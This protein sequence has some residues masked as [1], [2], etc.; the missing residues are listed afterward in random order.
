VFPTTDSS[1]SEENKLYLWVLRCHAVPEWATDNSDCSDS[2]S[3]HN[4]ANG[5]F[6]KTPLVSRVL[7]RMDQREYLCTEQS[8]EDSH[9][10]NVYL[11]NALIINEVTASKQKRLHDLSK[12]LITTINWYGCRSPDGRL[13]HIRGL[14]A[15]KLLSPSFS[16]VRITTKTPK[17]LEL[18]RS[19]RLSSS[20]SSWQSSE[21][22]AGAQA[23]GHMKTTSWQTGCGVVCGVWVPAVRTPGT[24]YSLIVH[25]AP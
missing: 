12:C 1:F 3:C 9:V 20:N 13:F 22:Q 17:W 14:V 16:W 11:Y 7:I 2:T 10:H 18:H 25:G 21:R 23:P 19:V 24:Y 8:I 5:L 15:K 6:P 4:Q